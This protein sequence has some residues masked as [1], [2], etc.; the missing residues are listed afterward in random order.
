MKWPCCLRSARQTGLVELA[1][2]NAKS[3]FEEKRLGEKA[4]RDLLEQIKSALHLTRTPN[5]IECF[6]IST[7]QG[8]KPVGSM[9]VF[10]DG[11]PAKGRYRR[12]AI[13]HVE[14]QDDF[15]MMREVLLRR[16]RRA[17]EEDDLPDLVLTRRGKAS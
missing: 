2:R 6:D 8:D 17:V 4:N 7:Q 10:E 1:N 3:G 5:R 9:A 13:K 12:F 14:G 16:Y 11:S 15:A